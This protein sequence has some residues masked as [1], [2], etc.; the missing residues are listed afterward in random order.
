MRKIANKTLQVKTNEMIY[1]QTEEQSF[2]VIDWRI[3]NPDFMEAGILKLQD[4]RTN[5]VYDYAIWQGD[6]DISSYYVC[7]DSVDDEDDEYDAIQLDDFGIHVFTFEDLTP[8]ARLSAAQF[9]AE[10]KRR[11]GHVYTF[12]RAYRKLL[13]DKSELFEFDGRP[14]R[15]DFCYI[16]SGEEMSQ[17]Y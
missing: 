8:F 13:K 16:P 3:D 17:V 15:Y 1:H 14:A 7:L 5:E 2:K 11:D 4:L 10:E 12:Q 9:Y 6:E